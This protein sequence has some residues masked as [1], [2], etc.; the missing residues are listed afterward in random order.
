MSGYES[1]NEPP[2]D[3]QAELLRAL[4]RT[5][6]R[7]AV[8][9]AAANKRMPP[10]QRD[11]YIETENLLRRQVKHL[12]SHNYSERAGNCDWNRAMEALIQIPLTLEH[13]SSREAAKRLCG[14]LR[15]FLNRF[16]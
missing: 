14:L 2:T 6:T 12:R 1:Q 4:E 7:L 5:R 16:D 15:D 8:I 10:D 11:Y 9:V 13:D 3:L